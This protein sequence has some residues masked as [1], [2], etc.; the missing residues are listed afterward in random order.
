[1]EEDEIIA[2]IEKALPSVVSIGTV[3]LVRRSL[4]EVI[5]SQGI[6]S[7]FI[8][9]PDGYILTNNHVVAQTRR[10]EVVLQDGGRLPGE[11]LGSD[12]SSDIAVVKVEQ[13]GL[14]SAE[15]GDSDKLRVGQ[16]VIA[17]GNPLGLAGGPTVTVGVISS[18]NRHIESRELVLEDLIQTDA[19]INP[20]NSGGPLVDR[21]GRVI[22]VNTAIIPFAQGIGFAIP[23][24][25]AKSVAEEL[26]QYG[27]VR[28]ASLGIVGT[29]LD[30]RAARYW[31]LPVSKGALVLR[32]VPGSAADLAGI[33]PGDVITQV[34]ERPIANMRELHREITSRRP[35]EEV[36]L[37]VNRKG[38]AL[39]LRAVLGRAS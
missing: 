24:N 33:A 36:E 2:A 1:M 21:F 17:I 31:G 8:L 13:R 39:T 35:G 18:L 29:D 30:E 22:G 10:I 15:L 23:I 3:R 14:P 20:G 11:I 9:D 16:R 7:G 4:F 25:K 12:P 26:I 5:P 32:I 19:A 28:R 6:G 34:G 37:Q 27:E 38:K